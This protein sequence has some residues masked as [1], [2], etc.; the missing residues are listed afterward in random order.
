[1]KKAIPAAKKKR[2]CWCASLPIMLLLFLAPACGKFTPNKRQAD[3]LSSKLKMAEEELANLQA[4]LKTKQQ[5]LKA[6]E[7]QDPSKKSNM[8]VMRDEFAKKE[9]KMKDAEQMLAELKAVFDQENERFQAHQKALPR[10]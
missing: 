6:L 5:E 9:A 1:M 7:T 4:Q 10:R 2:H 3:I 8:V